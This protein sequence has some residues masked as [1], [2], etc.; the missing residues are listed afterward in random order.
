MTRAMVVGILTLTLA[1]ATSPLLGDETAAGSP[2]RITYVADNVDQELRTIRVRAEVPN[3]DQ[4]LKPN[5]Y[6]QGFIRVQGD[7]EARMVVPEE[8]VQLLD[9][10]SVVFVQGPP[11]EGEAHVVFEVREV[12]A[13]ETLV[14]GRII[15]EGLEPDELVVTHGAFTLKA[16]LTKGAGGHDHAH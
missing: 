1:G 12:V 16:E 13:G 14:D 11:E 9:G 6:V 5:M 7:G 2:A 8:A 4:A 15:L 10:E 3:T